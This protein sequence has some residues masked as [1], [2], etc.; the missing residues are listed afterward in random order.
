MNRALPPGNRGRGGPA[1]GWPSRRSRT[2]PRPGRLVGGVTPDRG[3]STE[4]HFKVIKHGGFERFLLETLC[5][6]SA[7]GC[8]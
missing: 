4:R 7:D 6:W 8:F 2:L 3:D 1:S 5:A